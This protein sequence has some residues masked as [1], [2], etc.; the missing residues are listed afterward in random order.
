MSKTP[1]PGEAVHPDCGHPDWPDCPHYS[2][3]PA[4]FYDAVEAQ[5]KQILEVMEG[6]LFR[7]AFGDELADEVAELSRESL[8]KVDEARRTLGIEQPDR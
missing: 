3:T 5:E 7:G 4:Q 6:P 2:I 1:G 8:K